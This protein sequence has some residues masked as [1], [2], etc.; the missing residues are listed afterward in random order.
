MRNERDSELL[1]VRLPPGLEKSVQRIA[2]ELGTQPREVVRLAIESRL[3]VFV[4]RQER[5]KARSR[6]KHRPGG[7]GISIEGFS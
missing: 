7:A 4:K 6:A 5:G 2:E 1:P 3:K